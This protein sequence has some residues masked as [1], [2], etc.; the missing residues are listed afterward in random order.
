MRIRP[1]LLAGGTGTRLWPLSR[2][3][4]PKQF[5]S[6]FGEKS[7][8]QLSAE[9]FMESRDIKFNR[10][11]TVTNND[12]RFTVT[13][14]LST[15]GIDPGPILIEPV[16]KNTAPA[17]LAA[18]IFNEKFDP[19]EVFLVAPSDHLITDKEKF[20]EALRVGY[21]EV[22]HS[23]IVTFGIQPRR[24]E[25]G[26]GYL[27]LKQK[28]VSEPVD[29]VSFIEKPPL[30]KAKK[31]IASGNFLWNS[32]IFMFRAK[33]MLNLFEMLTPE[34]FT[35]VK[36]S[37]EKGT[38]DLG[39]FRLDD[40]IWESIE[41][42]SVDYA[43]MEKISNLSVVPF[44]AQWSDMGDWN[45]VAEQMVSDKNGVSLSKNS[46]QLDCSNSVLR[47]ENV[48][49]VL[50][51][52][53]V[54]DIVVIAMPDAVLVL[55]KNKSQDVKSVVSLLRGK[56]VIQADQFQ[57]DYRPWGWFETLTIK[58]S[59]QVK[60][61]YVKPGAALSLQSHRYRSEHW[62]VVE[63]TARV[64]VDDKIETIEEGQSIY[65]PLGAKHRMENPGKI[66]MVL[67]EV[68]TGTYLG[69]DDILRYEDLYKRK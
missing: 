10:H 6:L 39:F 53:G 20:H 37:V 67:I 56:N 41:P 26:F 22:N 36:N 19:N 15:V 50:V 60:K 54:K 61:I 31:M 25:I 16:G 3:S 68:Q 35:K 17:I 55:D 58:P 1:V 12:F 32:G 64:T 51:G 9:N 34:L 18:C 47:S 30:S 2:K 40:K 48:D 13:E 42:I 21:D 28:T 63:G 69:E 66:P 4:Y 62:V 24:P 38:E 29:L 45:S 11:I 33:E 5:S 44:N 52:L 57:K 23:K 14:Q 43:I 59:F 46:F 7:L 8:F 65:I 27:E 49:Q